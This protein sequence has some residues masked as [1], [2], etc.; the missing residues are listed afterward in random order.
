MFDV[1]HVAHRYRAWH[2]SGIAT[3]YGVTLGLNLRNENKDMLDTSKEIRYRVWWSLC[4]TE[5]ALAVMTGRP[6][7]MNE[8]DCTAPLPFPIEEEAFPSSGKLYG[9]TPQTF[10]PFSAHNSRSPDNSISTPSSYCS[11][12]KSVSAS[13]SSPPS[14]QSSSESGKS[15]AP[16]N[17]LYFVHYTLLST[18][19]QEVLG[20][21]YSPQ[22]MS[23]SWA[24]VQYLIGVHDLKLERWRSDL[25]SL[26][27]FGKKQRD[28]RFARQRMSLG[29]FYYSAKI[30]INR[31]CLCRVDRRIPNETGKSKDFN[32][33][34]AT[35]CV[36]AAKTMLGLLPDE[37]NP[38]GLYKL[39]PWWCLL[40]YLMQAATALM[41]ELA[42]RADH[43]PFEAEEIVDCAKKA[44]RWLNKMSDE[45]Y[46]AQRAWT[47]CYEML[48][49]VAGKVGRDVRD[50]SDSTSRS[51][52][53][54]E[55]DRFM[56]STPSYIPHQ[57]QYQN[58]L[59]DGQQYF[60]PQ[61]DH[62]GHGDEQAGNLSVFHPSIYTLHDEFMPYPQLET[63]HF[64][65]MFPSSGQM[66]I[67]ADGAYDVNGLFYG[68]NQQWGQGNVNEE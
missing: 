50:L 58:D 34:A 26:F 60:G 8:D 13:S 2:L 4:S 46:A 38:I 65:S 37:P 11:G 19:T 6:T 30:M 24:R 45:D 66:D 47:I 1:I 23:E 36:H 9:D 44:V 14:Q 22:T 39:A 52:S 15:V 35:N 10:R 59:V 54:T 3:R 28:Q 29:F 63:S 12:V 57:T 5:R 62:L 67:M 56:M 27:D 21:L 40:H 18:L 61:Q 51:R 64:S 25:P 32:R 31:P 68:M 53:T 16:N 49:R 20:H 42:I 41:L 43:M 33:A 7:S 55:G 17:A 48:R